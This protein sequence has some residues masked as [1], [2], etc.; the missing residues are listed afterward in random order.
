MAIGRTMILVGALALGSAGCG[1]RAPEAVAP[2]APA[3]TTA[4][5]GSPE[6]ETTAPETE[7]T[8]PTMETTE[9]ATPTTGAA[10]PTDDSQPQTGGP[11]A[12][13]EQTTSDRGNVVLDV[14]EL[15]SVDGDTGET[16]VEFTLTDIETD[17]SCPSDIADEPAN[18]Q[19]VAL[20]FQV[21][22]YPALAQQEYFDTFSIAAFDMTVFAPDGTRENDS[23]GNALFCLDPADEL[24]RD[25]G[26]G[27][28]AT[29]K[30]V[31]DTAQ[32]SGI[33]AYQSYLFDDL[34]WEWNY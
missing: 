11:E 9:E 25:M 31:L 3:P 32:Q 4:Q 20:T 15:A 21:R 18:E 2:E 14:G 24:P 19:F 29:G 7:T 6:T 16:I 23:S 5:E 8:S 22:T 10:S 33:V 26:P 28:Q 12:G 17:F 34:S 1:T 13:G 27:E 30:I